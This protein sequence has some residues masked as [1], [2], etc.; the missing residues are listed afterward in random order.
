MN[1]NPV[2]S[3]KKVVIIKGWLQE[4]LKLQPLTLK[5]IM[6]N[7]ITMLND[8]YHSIRTEVKMVLKQT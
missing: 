8:F 3:D 5:S 2:L 4:K 1:Q 7:I 6:I